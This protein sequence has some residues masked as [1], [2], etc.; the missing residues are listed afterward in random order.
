MNG[1][2][3]DNS[4]QGLLFEINVAKDNLQLAN[5][6]LKMM[7]GSTEYQNTAFMIPNSVF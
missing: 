2:K 4:T 6:N 5:E 7:A 3:P 1:V